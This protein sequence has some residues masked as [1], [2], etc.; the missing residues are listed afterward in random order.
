[1]TPIKHFGN[2]KVE[3]S[4]NLKFSTFLERKFSMMPSK[5]VTSLASCRNYYK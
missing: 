1:M 3:N 2:E 4:E 5:W